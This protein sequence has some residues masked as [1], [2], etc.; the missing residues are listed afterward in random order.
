MA[1]CVLVAM[2]I[3]RVR[4]LLGL[5][6]QKPSAGPSL[7]LLLGLGAV[8][9]AVAW[10]IA[11]GLTDPAAS[12][13]HGAQGPTSHLAVMAQLTALGILAPLGL[14]RVLPA[15][16]SEVRPWAR[17]QLLLVTIAAPAVM[18]F[19]H[20]PAMHDELGSGRRLEPL[21][22]LTVFL[23]GL[24]FWRA[25]LG[26]GRRVAP[27]AARQ[28]ALVV[29][30]QAT[31]L[32]GLALLLTTDPLHAGGDGLWGLS[33]VADQRLAGVLMLVAELGVMVPLL[34]SLNAQ[35]KVFAPQVTLRMPAPRT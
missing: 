29:A 24:L 33:A 31:A 2:I 3:A 6:G 32:L 27:P 21:P 17:R 4:Q 10:A 30:G 25:V 16:A 8:E 35:R 7:G 5:G 34:A 15:G 23:T 9:L 12:H 18:W 26:T 13:V 20:L 14:A 28:L 19:W 1:C 22:M 11:R